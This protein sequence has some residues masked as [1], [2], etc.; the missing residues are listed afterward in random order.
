MTMIQADKMYRIYLVQCRPNERRFWCGDICF[1]NV[2]IDA[3]K[4]NYYL[5]SLTQMMCKI[6]HNHPHRIA[7]VCITSYMAYK[8]IESRHSQT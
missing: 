4:Y 5:C 6:E 2:C 1:D 8:V 7:S 3:M